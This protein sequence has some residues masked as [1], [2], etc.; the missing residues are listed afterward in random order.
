MLRQVLG[1]KGGV[2]CGRSRSTSIS[3]AVKA[4]LGFPFT[5]RLQFTVMVGLV[6]FMF[7]WHRRVEYLPTNDKIS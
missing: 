3:K 1:G 6:A 4:A 2:L 5:R 7:N